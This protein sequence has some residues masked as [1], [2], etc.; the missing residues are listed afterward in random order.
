MFFNWKYET[1]MVLIQAAF[2]K[3]M[4]I[5]I[6]ILIKEWDEGDKKNGMI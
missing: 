6:M 3:L 4:K 5:E 1:L 2:M